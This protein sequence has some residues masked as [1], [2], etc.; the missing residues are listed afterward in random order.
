MEPV[1]PMQELVDRAFAQRPEVKQARIQIDSA[2]INLEGTKA[3]ML[4]QIDAVADLRNNALSGF[5]N[6]SP[7][8]AGLITPPPSVLVGGYS[9]A[10]SQLFFRDFP[11][12]SVE[13]MTIPLRNRAAEANMATAQVNLRM[14]EQSV[15][16]LENLILLEVQNAL[17]AVQQARIK[18]DV[19]AG[20]ATQEDY[21]TFRE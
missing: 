14:M 17:I 19:A 3:N 8:S 21:S 18:H 13:S 6:L 5:P 11:N 9:N 4:P 10:L 16:R 20:D 15:Q 2:R 1:E 12:Y 7:G